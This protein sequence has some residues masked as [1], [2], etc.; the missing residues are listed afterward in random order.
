MPIKQTKKKN[1]LAP[2]FP[3]FGLLLI[4][5]LGAIS[6]VVSQPAYNLLTD[7]IDSIPANNQQMQLVVGGTIFLILLML[8]GLV[9]AAFAP[10]PAKRVTEAELKKEKAQ[11]DKET[12]AR[13]KLRTELA[14]KA[15]RERDEAARQAGRK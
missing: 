12:R 6:F 8:C 9:Y 5:A 10:K 11:K 7:N 13:K 15:Q 4:A 14:R 1:P 2:F 3:V